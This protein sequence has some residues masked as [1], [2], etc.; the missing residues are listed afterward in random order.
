MKKLTRE[1]EQFIMKELKLPRKRRTKPVHKLHE[2]E[3]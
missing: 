3:G 1:Q 2:V